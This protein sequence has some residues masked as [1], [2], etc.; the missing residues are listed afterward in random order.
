MLLAE[1]KTFQS[2][3]RP[4]KMKN[5]KTHIMGI[6]LIALAVMTSGVQFYYNNDVG[7]AADTFDVDASISNTWPIITETPSDGDSDTTTPTNVG[8]N[9]TFT[10]I[11]EDA[12]S[13]QYY[14]AICK[15]DAVS[16][17]DNTAPTCTGGDWAISA[18]TDSS[19]AP[20]VPPTYTVLI[21]DAE[22]NAWYTFA[23]LP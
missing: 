20:T 18:A 8:D 16:A 14:L 15:T 5:F 17:G 12:N 19:L 3:R 4:K 21:G 9:V 7:I 11:A 13:D 1:T 10:A 22:T 6:A 23:E 2:A